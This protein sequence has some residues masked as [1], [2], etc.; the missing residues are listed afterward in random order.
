MEDEKDKQ[1]WQI[2]KRRAGFKR[3]LATYIIINGF[4]WAIW[5]VTQGHRD[6]DDGGMPWPIWSTLGWGVGLAFN[7]YSAYH[8]NREE[9]IMREY[10]KLKNREE[11]K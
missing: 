3:H 5:W 10:L 1:L 6:Y 11:G 8:D 9:D 7:Y 4:L 2:A